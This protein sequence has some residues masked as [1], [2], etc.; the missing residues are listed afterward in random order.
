MSLTIS[1][2][3]DEDDLKHFRGLMKQ[4]KSVAKEYDEEEILVATDGLLEELGDKK[5][6]AFVRDR[7]VI[8]ETMQAMLRDGAFALPAPERKRILSGL[9]YFL[10]PDDLIADDIPVLG[11]LDDAIMIELIGREL[12]H[13]MQAYKD[14]CAFRET[15]ARRRGLSDIP[16]NREKWMESKRQQLIGRIRDRRARGRTS[17]SRRGGR[18]PF[19]LL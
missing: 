8:I 1:F 15:E 13:E 11:F 6:P 7:V 19:S 14:F 3:L 10:E 4:A 17:R 9:A 2:E 16:M 18:S 5:L 12:E